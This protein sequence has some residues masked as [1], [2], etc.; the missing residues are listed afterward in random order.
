M[1]KE[2]KMKKAR[3]YHPNV[4]DLRM[5][6]TDVDNPDLDDNPNVA[7]FTLSP[8]AVRSPAQYSILGATR[9]ALEGLLS[10]RPSLDLNALKPMGDRTPW[11]FKK[12]K[13]EQAKKE[14]EEMLDIQTKNLH[15]YARL[16]DAISRIYHT[17]HGQSVL[18]QTMGAAEGSL[19]R[20]HSWLYT[21]PSAQGGRRET[22]GSGRSDR[23]G[24]TSVPGVLEDGVRETWRPK[25]CPTR[26]ATEF[27]MVPI[28]PKMED[29]PQIKPKQ[30]EEMVFEVYLDA[31]PGP[32]CGC[33]MREAFDPY[34][35]PCGHAFCTKCIV[36]TSFFL[37]RDNA[38]A[39]SDTRAVMRCPLRHCKAVIPCLPLINGDFR[40]QRIRP[41]DKE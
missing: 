17:R 41:D 34:T 26:Y 14:R 20:R 13:E 4:V 2:D 36:D 24:K 35:L 12:S 1:F 29:E 19:S 31:K 37:L 7:R 25:D 33:C 39:V 6:D 11:A 8:E 40:F 5:E 30:H 9:P 18:G 32:W 27:P 16:K 38:Q 23:L 28:T 21:G 3:N 22:A 10:R 15:F